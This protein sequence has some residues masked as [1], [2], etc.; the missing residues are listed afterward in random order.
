MGKNEGR[1]GERGTEDEKE[2]HQKGL[3]GGIQANKKK[4]K[5][6]GTVGGFVRKVGN[7]SDNKVMRLLDKGGGLVLWQS[8]RKKLGRTRPEN[9]KKTQGGSILVGKNVFSKLG[10]GGG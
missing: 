2:D 8:S 6:D 4:K 3:G 7:H 9:R 10:W 1:A 5:G